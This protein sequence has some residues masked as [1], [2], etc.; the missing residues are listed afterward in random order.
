VQIYN[1]GAPTDE[2]GRIDFDAVSDNDRNLSNQFG[3][4]FD[5]FVN[6]NFFV[7]LWQTFEAPDSE[8]SELINDWRYLLLCHARQLL[9]ESFQS[10]PKSRFHRR[11]Q[12]QATRLFNVQI[13]K[14]KMFNGWL[15]E[16]EHSLMNSKREQYEQSN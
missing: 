9:E 6:Q 3:N 16:Y 10:L 2:S 15:A 5:D 1:A 4:Q 13:F 14:S 12:A 11:S 7:P 8:K